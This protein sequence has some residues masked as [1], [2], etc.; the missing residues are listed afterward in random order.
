MNVLQ[1][2]LGLEGERAGE[3]E[4]EGLGNVIT[5]VLIFSSL[6]A[7]VSFFSCTRYR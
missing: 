2:V 4:K 3:I 7:F 6:L 1:V 5:I